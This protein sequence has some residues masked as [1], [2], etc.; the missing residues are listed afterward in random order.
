[1]SDPTTNPT[2][3]PTD[4]RSHPPCPAD[5]LATAQRA[6]AI[7][8]AMAQLEAAYPITIPRQG[9]SLDAIALIDAALLAPPPPLDPD[10]TT[11]EL[12]VVTKVS[13]KGACH[14]DPRATADEKVDSDRGTPP[15]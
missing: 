15:I 1:M 12:A 9:A 14:S 2:L 3:A 4:L 11:A 5:A 7:N 10:A 13:R 8:D 6:L